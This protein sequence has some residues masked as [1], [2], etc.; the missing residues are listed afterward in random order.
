M[1][2]YRSRWTVQVLQVCSQ[3]VALRVFI[4]RGERVSVFPRAALTMEQQQPCAHRLRVRY[5]RSWLIGVFGAVGDTNP[6]GRLLPRVLT[7]LTGSNNKQGPFF[8]LSNANATWTRP[9]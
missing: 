9:R 6:G 8:E 3:A 4:E 5:S 1:R 7:G 2:A